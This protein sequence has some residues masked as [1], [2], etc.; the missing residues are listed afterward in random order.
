MLIFMEGGKP[1]NPEKNP[2]GKEENNTSNNF[3]SHMVPGLS[4]NP[5]PLESQR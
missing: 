4:L 2:C 3:N 1:D 5:L